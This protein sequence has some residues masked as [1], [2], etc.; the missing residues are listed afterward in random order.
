[1]SYLSLCWNREWRCYTATCNEATLR[2]N[3]VSQTVRYL[4]PPPPRNERQC[5]HSL[6][7]SLQFTYSPRD[8]ILDMGYCI[9]NQGLVPLSEA[10]SR[11]NSKSSR[12][13]GLPQTGACHCRCLHTSR[14]FG[15]CS[16]RSQLMEAKSQNTPQR[17]G[18]GSGGRRGW[19]PSR[20]G[21]GCFSSSQG[22]T[23]VSVDISFNAIPGNLSVVA[24]RSHLDS[25]TGM[26]SCFG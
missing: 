8:R 6:R 2:S 18:A 11:H 19:T 14:C 26:E 1:M 10:A 25:S 23:L 9:L 24:D 12:W 22:S 16:S 20:R 21:S 17:R 5:S 4:E 7:P 13:R 3:P 15:I